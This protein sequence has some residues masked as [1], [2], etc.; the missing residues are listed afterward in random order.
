MNNF[1]TKLIN[2]KESIFD[3]ILS[4][5]GIFQIIIGISIRFV[6]LFS[7]IIYLQK[8]SRRFLV[9]IANQPSPIFSNPIIQN[10][11]QLLLKIIY[12]S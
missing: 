8:F 6:S 10:Y 3:N 1:K 5:A 11:Y 9:L 2:K 7:K 12:L 4:I